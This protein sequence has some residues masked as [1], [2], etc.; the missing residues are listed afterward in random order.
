MCRS[1]ELDPI[2]NQTC[3]IISIFWKKNP[4]AGV[5]KCEEQG[6]ELDWS[7]FSKF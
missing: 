1:V 7:F 2:W 5:L 3:L 4:E 6:L